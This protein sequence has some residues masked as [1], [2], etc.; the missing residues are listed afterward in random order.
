M[1]TLV[2]TFY[3]GDDG[4]I[5]PLRLTPEYFAVA[6]TAP[7]GP[8]TSSIRAK[9]SKSNREFGI[10]PR[11][12]RLT[13]TIGTAPDTF[14]RYAT[15]SVLTPADFALPAFALGATITIDTVAYTVIGREGEDY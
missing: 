15:L 14:R 2:D 10:R 9:I 12:V 3:E 8:A 13:R 4:T 5:Y 7:T 6:G 11:F 1:T